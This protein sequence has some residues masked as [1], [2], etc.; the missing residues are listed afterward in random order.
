M[1]FIFISG[2]AGILSMWMYYK[3]L[4]QLP[5]W[6]VSV[7]E[8]AYPAMGM[9]FASFYSFEQMSFLQ[10]LGLLSFLTF[11]SLLMSKSKLNSSNVN[12]PIR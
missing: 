9:V 1:R 4:K 10:N 8:L 11:I 2:I 12:K 3:G 6:K 5:A 7:F